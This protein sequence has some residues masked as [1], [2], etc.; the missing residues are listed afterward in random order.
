MSCL[1]VICMVGV[2][3]QALTPSDRKHKTH[4]AASSRTKKKKYWKIPVEM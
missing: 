4:K 3:S 1:L 2:A